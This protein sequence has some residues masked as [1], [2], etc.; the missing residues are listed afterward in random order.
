MKREDR[1]IEGDGAKKLGKKKVKTV[2]CCNFLKI[3]VNGVS[4]EKK[5]RGNQS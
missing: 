2:N 1:N 4:A 5:E 3:Y